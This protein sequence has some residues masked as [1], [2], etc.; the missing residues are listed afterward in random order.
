M[1]GTDEDL[2][3]RIEALEW[4]NKRLRAA[5]EDS[6]VNVDVAAWFDPKKF[7]RALQQISLLQLPFYLVMGVGMLAVFTTNARSIFID[8]PV[9]GPVP[10]ID[11]GNG[12]MIGV[13]GI[14]TG[15][16]AFGGLAFGVIAMGGGAIGIVAFGG[17]AMGVFAFGGGAVGL[18][19]IGG[20]AVGYVAMGGGGVGV[21]VMAER[22]YGRHVLAM[23]RQDESAAQ[24][25]RRYVPRLSLAVTKPTPVVMAD[26]A[27]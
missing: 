2:Q 17:G 13:P 22:G 14:G 10:L 4:E 16:I 3:Q 21:Y 5:V 24:F 8:F 27:D 25:F 1:P 15:I 6:G 26:V 19:A 23:N 20:G 12:M 9:L 7:R 18:I 11:P